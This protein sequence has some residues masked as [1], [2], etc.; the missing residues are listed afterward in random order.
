MIICLMFIGEDSRVTSSVGLYKYDS[1]AAE[2]VFFPLTQ[3]QFFIA[4]RK[5]GRER[6]KHQCKNSINQLP[7]VCAPVG[8]KRTTCCVP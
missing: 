4:F 7:L 8:I 1:M 2:S 3:G 6:E 5:R